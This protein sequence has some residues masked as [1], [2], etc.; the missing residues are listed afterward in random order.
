[1][2]SSVVSVEAVFGDEPVAVDD[3][4]AFRVIIVTVVLTAIVRDHRRAP[5]GRSARVHRRVAR[6]TV[7]ALR[8]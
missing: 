5:Y 1:M 6:K 2:A 7:A 3:K 8:M 4:V